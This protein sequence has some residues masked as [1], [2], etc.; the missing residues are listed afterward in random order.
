[1]SS[2]DICGGEFTAT[3]ASHG[4]ASSI[5]RPARRHTATAQRRSRIRIDSMGGPKDPGGKADGM[6]RRAP[7]SGKTRESPIIGP[8]VR[9]LP[10]SSVPR[11]CPN[12]TRRF[13]LPDLIQMYSSSRRHPPYL[14]RPSVQ[15]AIGVFYKYLPPRQPRRYHR[16]RPPFGFL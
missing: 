3:S 14:A 6:A 12:A 1:M 7:L 13:S 4:G 2:S 16:G 5:S 10:T 11:K 8:P 9:S 15:H